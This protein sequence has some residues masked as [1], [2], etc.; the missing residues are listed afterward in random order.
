[1][2]GKSKPARV[3]D[4]IEA[5]DRG[6]HV[7]RYRPS[8]SPDVRVV[9]ASRDGVAVHFR[10]RRNEAG[11]DVALSMEEVGPGGAVVEFTNVAAKVR[12]MTAPPAVPFDPETATDADVLA[13][14]SGRTVEWTNATTGK[15]EEG[16][17]GRTLTV[18]AAS[19]GKLHGN[20]TV[21]FADAGSGFRSVRLNAI[22][23]VS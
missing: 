18:T 5:A 15:A 17:V 23:R 19:P 4:E 16:R 8:S 21:T 22:T 10:W 2:A 14:L 11:R 12:E 1:M 3:A 6:W 7:T 9:I 13:A 20:R